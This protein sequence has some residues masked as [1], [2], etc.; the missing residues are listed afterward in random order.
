M[1]LT[2]KCLAKHPEDTKR[3]LGGAKVLKETKGIGEK[4]FTAVMETEKEMD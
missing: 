4:L 2:A 1:G 3:Y